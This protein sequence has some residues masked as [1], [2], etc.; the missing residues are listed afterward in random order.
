M[1]EVLK[2]NF[3]NQFVV[4][5]ENLY[6]ELKSRLDTVI[7]DSM[8]G[9]LREKGARFDSSVNDLETFKRNI[10]SG[11]SQKTQVELANLENR[12]NQELKKLIEDLKDGSETAFRN[13][14]EKLVKFGKTT[15]EM[16]ARMTAMK[17]AYAMSPTIG[18][19]ALGASILAPAVYRTAK[20]IKNKSEENTKTALD[21]M[22]LKLC[23]AK[24]GEKQRFDISQST[25]EIVY[26]NLR[27][28]G[29]R[30]NKEDVAL[31]L[32]DITKL[33]NARKEH[34]VKT[35]NNIK[36]NFFDVEREMKQTK[37]SLKNI[38]ETIG[39]D[40]VEPIST[41]ALYGIS[42]GG[43]L[44]DVA[45]DAVPAVITALSVGGI[46]GNLTTA[47]TAGGTQYAASKLLKDIP[48]LGDAIEI[49]NN[50]ETMAA[51][52]GV[53][54]GG[55][56][57]AKVL[58]GLV[59]KGAKGL[60]NS[61]KRRKEEREGK[62][63]LNKDIAKRLK[64]SSEDVEKEID[65]RSDK[66]VLL[67]VIR[68]SLISKGIQ[69][70]R[71]IN[72][73]E[74]LKVYLQQLDN[75]Q[76]RDVYK[77]ASTLEDI[78]EDS[79][80]SLKK[81]LGRV[82][83]TAYWGGVI[84]LAGL[85]VYDA[86]INPGF[87]EGIRIRGEQERVLGENANEVDVINASEETLKG[88][89][90]EIESEKEELLDG[91]RKLLPENNTDDRWVLC[92]NITH[93]EH[94]V[95]IE[96]LELNTKEGLIKFFE[97]VPP[98]QQEKLELLKMLVGESKN[99]TI[100]ELANNDMIKKSI[101]DI[102]GTLLKSAEYYEINSNW[103]EDPIDKGIRDGYIADFI[104]SRFQNK[105]EGIPLASA[106]SAEILNFFQNADEETIKYWS[107]YTEAELKSSDQIKTLLENVLDLPE[108][109]VDQLMMETQKQFEELQQQ[110]HLLEEQ[111]AK[112]SNVMDGVGSKFTSN[113]Y[114]VFSGGAKI[115]TIFGTVQQTI[116]TIGDKIK[117][118][119]SKIK[120]P[121][122]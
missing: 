70:P 41:A 82:A 11:L 50:T 111:M 44:N 13:F 91:I 97:E 67:D 22:L 43:L 94:K 19:V 47:F 109:P 23:T 2:G 68:D 100:E 88:Q 46:T 116:N 59:Y 8:K 25:M 4:T 86:F 105:L 92:K 38:Q 12:L 34:V 10:V 30:V 81:T 117:G 96:H 52:T 36:G 32:R 16:A 5:K 104:N 37:I 60:Y 115:G 15:T 56:I 65:F 84:A 69:I 103:F 78:K 20:N 57:L 121:F 55:V 71:N 24:D 49:V 54:V 98:E 73:S 28:E 35:I 107:I 48:I 113:P 118:I 18:G 6:D 119:F 29:V 101:N 74:E 90:A 3:A 45:P 95:I 39:K 110:Q 108:T 26:D 122:R 31:F 77:I 40:V 1:V 9:Y 85:G 112:S 21:V 58:P 120:N 87:L 51:S 42:V 89:I 61:I 75:N 83:K 76:K 63:E 27:A 33:D 17:V 80:K 72:S 14:T 106:D 99:C 53:M 7:L 102:G 62:K 114:K 66:D 64:E 79:D 93:A